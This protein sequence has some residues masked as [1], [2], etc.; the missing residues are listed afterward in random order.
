MKV[1][2][3]APGFYKCDKTDCTMCQHVSTTNAVKSTVT[4]IPFDH[5][6]PQNKI[7][8]LILS[9]L[10]SSLNKTKYLISDMLF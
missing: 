2:D 3:G 9:F 8:L 4:G 10:S 5:L 6:L 7:Y 1:T